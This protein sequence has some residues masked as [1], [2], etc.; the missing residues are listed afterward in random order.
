MTR[1]TIE[2]HPAAEVGAGHADA[3]TPSVAP[4][5]GGAEAD[6]QRRARAVDDAREHVAAEGVGAE[7]VLAR[8]AAPSIARV[9]GRERVVRR[10]DRRRRRP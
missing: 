1:C 5:S 6:Q 2:V 10:E 9:V 8:R 7:P 4:R 3:A